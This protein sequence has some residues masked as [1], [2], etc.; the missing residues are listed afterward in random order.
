MMLDSVLLVFEVLLILS[1]LYFSVVLLSDEEGFLFSDFL[2]E[3]GYLD[4][5][6]VLD[7]GQS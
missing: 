2:Q 7:S 3:L 6:F 5:S 4:F 1:L